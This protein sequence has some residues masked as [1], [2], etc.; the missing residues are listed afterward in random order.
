MSEVNK[1]NESV[2]NPKDEN[3]VWF[4]EERDNVRNLLVL[5]SANLSEEAESTFSA[6]ELAN[7]IFFLESLIYHSN[8]DCLLTG[9]TKKESQ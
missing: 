3:E 8:C 1:E 4:D 6:K 5:Y 2:R 9:N 7:A